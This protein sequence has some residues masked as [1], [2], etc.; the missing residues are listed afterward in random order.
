M[1]DRK[2]IKYKIVYDYTNMHAELV[3]IYLANGWDLYGKPFAFVEGKFACFCQGM[4]KY[5]VE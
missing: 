3:E 5:D 4:V 1:S 2:I